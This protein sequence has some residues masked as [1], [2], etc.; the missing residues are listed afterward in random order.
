MDEYRISSLGGPAAAVPG[1]GVGGAAVAEDLIIDPNSPM[2][3]EARKKKGKKSILT[4]W[5]FIGG[6]AVLTTGAITGVYFLTQTSG[7]T[8]SAAT[9]SIR[10]EVAPY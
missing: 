1:P 2:F 8:D 7:A 10:V 6:V 3:A 5:W 4:E 9:G